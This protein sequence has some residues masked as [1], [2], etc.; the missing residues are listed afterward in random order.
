MSFAQYAEVETQVLEMPYEQKL[1]RVRH[2]GFYF[3]K[4]R[5]CATQQR[6]FVV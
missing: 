3:V 1:Q 4:D 2:C 5:C 6:F